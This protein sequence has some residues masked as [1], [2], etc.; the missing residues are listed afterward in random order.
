[1]VTIEELNKSLSITKQAIDAFKGT[2]PEH[3]VIQEAWQKIM[4]FLNENEGKLGLSNVAKT[5]EKPKE[6][7]VKEK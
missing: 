4:T 7:S 2:Y 3:M 6:E 5:E 1:M